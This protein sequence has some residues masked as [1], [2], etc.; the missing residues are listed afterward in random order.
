MHSD[1]EAKIRNFLEEQMLI[2][3]KDMGIFALNI[4]PQFGD[5]LG[6]YLR[7]L[8]TAYQLK[9]AAPYLKNDQLTPEALAMPKSFKSVPYKSPISR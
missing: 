6:E 2:M 4:K 9:K 5:D 3:E 8:N 7:W 1:I